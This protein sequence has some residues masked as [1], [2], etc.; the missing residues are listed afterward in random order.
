MSPGRTCDGTSRI[1]T[2]AHGAVA[3]LVEHV[4]QHRDSQRIGVQLVVAGEL[5]EA[6]HR[7]QD[8]RRDEIPIDRQDDTPEEVARVALV[9]LEPLDQALAGRHDDLGRERDPVDGV[10]GLVV[11]F[12]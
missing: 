12:E 10:E 1:S 5:R 2:V 9:A 8:E 11:E 4:D 7:V 3:A 6:G